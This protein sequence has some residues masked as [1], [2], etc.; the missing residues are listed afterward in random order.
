V[1]TPQRR[2]SSHETGS[3]PIP[4]ASPDRRDQLRVANNNP[5][6]DQASQFA[7][8]CNPGPVVEVAPLKRPHAA[9]QLFGRPGAKGVI[10][11]QEE[12]GINQR[13]PLSLTAF[14]VLLVLAE[15]SLRDLL[16]P[17][18]MPRGFV[19]TSELKQRLT[20]YGVR[21]LSPH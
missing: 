5:S 2:E 18:W 17:P 16:Q 21:R 13:V 4:D 10:V 9:A 12:G 20:D 14:A 3:Q 19:T 8:G 6:T 7:A 15:Q 1:S 11:I